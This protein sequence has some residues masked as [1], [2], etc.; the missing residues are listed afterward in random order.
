[1]KHFSWEIE[2]LRAVRGNTHYGGAT[3]IKVVVDPWLATHRGSTH[4]RMFGQAGAHNAAAAGVHIAPACIAAGDDLDQ[5][6]TSMP[7]CR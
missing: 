6:A 4:P 7:A 1:M 5:T 2:R 3:V